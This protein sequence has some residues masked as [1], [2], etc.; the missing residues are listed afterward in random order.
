MAITVNV[1]DT[2]VQKDSPAITTNA[3]ST[4]KNGSI[5]EKIQ[6][7]GD[8]KTATTVNIQSVNTAKASN[9]ISLGSVT[10]PKDG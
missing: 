9:D 5:I 8:G 10:Y 1:Q 6:S 2:N 4:K 7:S 3:V